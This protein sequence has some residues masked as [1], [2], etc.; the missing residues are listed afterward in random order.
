MSSA[1]ASSTDGSN[2]TTTGGA[3]PPPPSLSSYSPVVIIGGGPTGLFLSSLLSQYNVPSIL[4][5]KRL[6]QDIHLHPQAH[7]INLRSMEILR[8]CLP[9][10]YD[11]VLDQSPPIQDW[12]G[13]TFGS[14][15]LGRQIARVIHP[16]RGI[17]V[18]QDGNGILSSSSSANKTSHAYK[19]R[20]QDD[21]NADHIDNHPNI[22]A[23]CS[24]T[25]P[26]HLAQNQ[27]ASL[28]LQEAQHMSCRVVHPSA[29]LSHGETVQYVTEQPQSHQ[30]KSSNSII[31]TQLMVQTN[32]RK[33]LTNFVVVAEGCHSQTR[34]QHGGSWVGN[35]ILQHL[36]NV[37][38]R[39][40][41]QLSQRLM[42]DKDRVGMLHFV[43]HK[44]V[45]GAFVC[46]DVQKGEWVLQIPYFAPFQDASD[47]TVSRVKEMV[48]AGLGVDG[49]DVR[50]DPHDDDDD[51]EILSIKPWTM[52]ATVAKEYIL[53]KTSNRIILAGDAA[54]A[55]PPAGGFGM[56]TGLQDVHNLAWRLACLIQQQQQQQQQDGTQNGSGDESQ[57]YLI[58]EML[59][60]YESERRSVA[61]QNA[62]L[63]VRNYNRTLDIAKACYL[64]ADHP[65]V[66]CKVM[67]SPPMSLI[68]M[69]VRQQM[70]GTAV[71][72]AM[73]PLVNLQYEGNFYGDTIARN[74]QRIL[75]SGGGL[76]LIFPRYEIGFSYDPTKKLH[77]ADDTAGYHPKI[78]I[79]YR[80]PHLEVECL[81]TMTHDNNNDQDNVARTLTLTDI[82]SQLKQRW[83]SPSAPRYCL[84]LYK[85]FL[86]QN[87]RDMAE[88]WAQD[89]CPFSFDIVELYS[90]RLQAMEKCRSDLQKN[91][92]SI[93]LLDIRHQFLD[94]L[95]RGDDDVD[96]NRSFHALLVRPDGHIANLRAFKSPDPCSKEGHS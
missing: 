73:M 27:F 68:P 14:S 77:D 8:H 63:S 16:V 7:Y 43:F 38:F 74:V 55:F 6:P 50:N 52:G 82:E 33:I 21:V 89:L 59:Q 11:K 1:L 87:M 64:N 35:P 58:K 31:A 15:V 48:L 81:S 85:P 53:G 65:S 26:S 72:A 41:L 90:N 93:V 37:H 46:H 94:L 44:D 34:S 30:P 17:D 76:P 42:Q 71:K 5:E 95:S 66:L 40:G 92:P 88:A 78:A 36:I 32:Q 51:L 22:L 80:L 67:M 45:V 61:T 69:S 28:L 96:V 10:V 24:V 12:E 57:S 60:E 70:F 47:F 39:T 4:L 23:A 86:S 79:G 9:R 25:R 62:A 19:R 13:F 56:N 18:G 20:I 29:E 54:H 49:K 83:N 91:H 2:I 84:L 75:S 3:S